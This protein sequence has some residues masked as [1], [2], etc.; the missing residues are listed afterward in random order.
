MLAGLMVFGGLGG[1]LLADLCWK[2]IMKR[3][4][5]AFV[6]LEGDIEGEV[7]DEGITTRSTK[8][9]SLRRWMGYQRAHV[10]AD[11][12]VLEIAGTPQLASIQIVARSQFRGD[13]DWTQFLEA[14]RTRVADVTDA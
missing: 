4:W 11:I 12:V 2:R 6:E 14:V 13:E 7:T 3:S 8:S 1:L 9:E 10:G 5:H